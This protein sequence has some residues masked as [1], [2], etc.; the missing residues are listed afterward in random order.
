[1]N[2]LDI[3]H[4]IAFGSPNLDR[5]RLGSY[6]RR[7]RAEHGSDRVDFDVSSASCQLRVGACRV[8][9]EVYGALRRV[10]DRGYLYPTTLESTRD[11]QDRLHQIRCAQGRRVGREPS[12]TV[13][14]ARYTWHGRATLHCLYSSCRLTP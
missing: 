4:G 13:L 3:Y 11:Q 1:M 7:P 2:E 9:I 5:G 12:P 14:T 8:L 10:W 6:L